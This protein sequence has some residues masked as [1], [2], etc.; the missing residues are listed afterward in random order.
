V[1]CALFI[2]KQDW[3]SYNLWAY[4]Y[5]RPTTARPGWSSRL[6]GMYIKEGH[7][8]TDE[9]YD[10]ETARLKCE[11]AIDCWG[12]ATQ[13][14][15]CGGKYR[16]SH[17]AGAATLYYSDWNT[18]NLWAYTYTRTFSKRAGWSEYVM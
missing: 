17:G 6:D 4:K 3:R 14:N 1:C 13:S 11:T 12:I 5:T 2:I 7:G 16:V 8:R 15:V 9:C 10:Y 18:Y